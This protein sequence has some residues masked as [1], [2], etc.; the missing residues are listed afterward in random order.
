MLINEGGI[1]NSVPD[2]SAIAE[3]LGTM[4][5]KASLIEGVLDNTL[6]NS[7]LIV[8]CPE[9]VDNRWHINFREILLHALRALLIIPA[10]FRKGAISVVCLLDTVLQPSIIETSHVFVKFNA[11]LNVSHLPKLL[12]SVAGVII[13]NKLSECSTNRLER[14]W[15]SLCRSKCCDCSINYEG[16]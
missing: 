14:L 12:R 5:F 4:V 6:I 7:V 10:N 8:G 16:S 2:P 1:V 9:F 3:V 15:D 13:C 11:V